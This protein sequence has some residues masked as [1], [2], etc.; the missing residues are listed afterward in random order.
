MFT[1]TSVYICHL[2]GAE[3]ADEHIVICCD[4][5]RNEQPDNLCVTCS[6]PIDQG[7]VQC[8]ECLTGCRA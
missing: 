2:C 8:L 3:Q 6:T 5:A 4:D 7:F 1:F